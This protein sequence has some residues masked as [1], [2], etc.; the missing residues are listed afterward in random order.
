MFLYSSPSDFFRFNM[1]KC[2]HGWY[3][4]WRLIKN[5]DRCPYCRAEQAEEDRD[6]LETRDIKA[7]ELIEKLETALKLLGYTLPNKPL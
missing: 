3:P 6:L 2:K 4:E 1:A 7:L 5:D